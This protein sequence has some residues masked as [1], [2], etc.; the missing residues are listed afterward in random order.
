MQEKMKT[1][2]I[3]EN[4][5][6]I[7]ELLVVIAIITILAALLLPALNKAKGT[8]L[9]ATCKSNLKQIGFCGTQ[10]QGDFND[11]AAPDIRYPSMTNEGNQQWSYYFGSRY[12]NYDTSA[13]GMQPGKWK[14]FSCPED[15]RKAGGYQETRAKLSYLI[16]RLWTYNGNS[17]TLF[18]V[19]NPPSEYLD[20]K[21]FT[22]SKAW[23][24]ID[25]NENVD[26]YKTTT[27]GN[28][29][30]DG[31]NFFDNLNACGTL[32]HGSPRWNVV[33]V[34]GHASERSKL[35]DSSLNLSK[36]LVIEP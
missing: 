4:N 6:T 13:S 31:K 1:K 25:M 18:K 22:P 10:Y 26:N 15:K 5:F 28:F 35:L 2:R 33:Y 14:I 9:T 27:V 17:G 30:N 16:I 7:I 8:A 29:R 11:Y 36:S 20:G 12:M 24:F 21:S 3:K 34:D 32:R 19:T 23:Y